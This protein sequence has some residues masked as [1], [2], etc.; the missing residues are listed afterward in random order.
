ME[1]NLNQVVGAEQTN[2]NLQAP[3]VEEE[4][5]ENSAENTLIT[6]ATIVL[7]LG[8]LG[9]IICLFTLCFIRVPTSIYSYKTELRFNPAGF[10]TTAM[11]LFSALI[12]WSIMKVLAN[13]SITLKNI[14]K[15]IK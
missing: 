13:I 14:D 11:V 1:E 7:I 4:R 8:I 12:S 6:I 15:K 10:A 5:V 9:T 2:D 3:E